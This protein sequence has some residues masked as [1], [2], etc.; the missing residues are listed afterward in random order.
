MNFIEN[1]DKWALYG[2]NIYENRIRQTGFKK[3]ECL[4]VEYMHKIFTVLENNARVLRHFRNIRRFF[5]NVVHY[6]AI[7]D[8]DLAKFAL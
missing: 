2:F 3:I 6:G 1:S 5:S 8:S 4:S 7:M